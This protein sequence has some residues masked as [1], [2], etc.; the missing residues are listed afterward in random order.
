MIMMPVARPPG[1]SV[2]PSAAARPGHGSNRG[3]NFTG[4]VMVA[5]E[6]QVRVVGIFKPITGISVHAESESTVR[7]GTGILKETAPKS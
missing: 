6:L 5:I 7:H 2:P 3:L 4:T 1:L